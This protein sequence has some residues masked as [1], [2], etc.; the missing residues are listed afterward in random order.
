MAIQLWISL[1]VLPP[2]TTLL[3]RVLR[4]A[5]LSSVPFCVNMAKRALSKLV[6]L[7]PCRCER[8]KQA[9]GA[10]IHRSVQPAREREERRRNGL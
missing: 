6:N 10:G 4:P 1:L 3:R 9:D 8:V 7:A 5:N 2:N